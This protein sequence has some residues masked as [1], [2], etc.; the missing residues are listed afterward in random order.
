MPLS[1][2]DAAHLVAR[3]DRGQP[4]G[5]LGADDGVEV[6]KRLLE[7]VAVEKQ[8]GREGLG[9]CGR[10]DGSVDGEVVTK[11]LISGSAISSGWRLLWKRMK[12]RIQPT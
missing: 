11:A 1:L 8:Q 3:E 5:T 10:A 6:G 2:E 7:D 12:R 9:L 4:A